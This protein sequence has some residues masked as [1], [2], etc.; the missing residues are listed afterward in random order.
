MFENAV[1]AISSIGIVK[2]EILPYLQAKS[3]MLAEDLRLLGQRQSTA[4]TVAR[5]LSFSCAASLTPNFHTV[6]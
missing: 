4:V 3:Q 2:A 6:M 1:A 5:R